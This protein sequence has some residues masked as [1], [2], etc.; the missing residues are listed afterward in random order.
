[1][2]KSVAFLAFLC[3][4]APVQSGEPEKTAKAVAPFLDE[5]AFAVVRLDVAG[6]DPDAILQKL[7]GLGF[8]VNEMQGKLVKHLR[9]EVVNA[10]GKEAY[11]V[12]SMADRLGE[13]FGVIPVNGEEAAKALSAAVAASVPIQSKASGSTVLL[14]SKEALTRLRDVQAGSFPDLAKAFAAAGEGTIQAVVMPPP[15]LRRAVTELIPKLPAELGEVPVAVVDRG[16]VWIAAGVNI[17]PKMSIR[18]VVK[19]RD[20]AAA[21]D[22]AKL[23]DSCMQALSL[24]QDTKETLP[25][26]IKLFPQLSPKAQGDRVV[27]S[28]D[29]QTI[30]KLLLPALDKMRDS[31]ARMQSANNMKQ[32]GIAMHSYVD[33]FKSLPA[34]ASYDKDG[35]PLLSWRV[36]ILP[37]VEH[38]RLYKEFHL[39]EPWD[40]EHNKQ[41][42]ARMPAIYR[43]P[44]AK[45]AGAGK[46]TYQ[47]PLGKHALFGG[48]KGLNF[49]RDVPDGT[50]NTIM[51]VETNDD[52]AVT[53]TKPADF[54]TEVQNPLKALLRPGAR[55]FHVGMADGSVRFISGRI[56]LDT[57]RAAFT[58]DGGEVLGNDF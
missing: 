2:R 19:S 40:S 31:S 30:T 48:P 44:Q 50:S 51:V 6:A 49:P 13:P 12:W 32:M 8:P 35:K 9:G 58:R 21:R 42:I 20:E 3:L 34:H 37:F 1:M 43:S 27:L 11:L 14:G 33:T 47:V 16:I 4:L 7:A 57:L 36:H 45:K 56:S 25:E 26:W 23:A 24:S 46:T 55:G 28:L 53:W 39:D 41:L 29:D 10:G 17:A 18:Y 54:N 22:F 52:N 15:T 5:Q 38:D